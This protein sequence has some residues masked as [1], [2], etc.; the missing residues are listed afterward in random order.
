M[1]VSCF[2]FSQSLQNNLNR[3]KKAVSVG[4]EM[5]AMCEGRPRANKKPAS[6]EAVFLINRKYF[7]ILFL[8]RVRQ[9]SGTRLNDNLYSPKFLCVARIFFSISKVSFAT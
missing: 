7:T 9:K 1:I 3:K 5:Q 4:Y 6:I 8:L 2:Q